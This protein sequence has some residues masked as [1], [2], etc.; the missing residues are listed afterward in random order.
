MH[1]P[2]K[3]ISGKVF[4]FFLMVT[5]LIFM[6]LGTYVTQLFKKQLKEEFCFRVKSELQLIKG[7]SL[8]AIKDYDYFHL[9]KF[10]SFFLQKDPDAVYLLIYEF[11]PSSP[12][13]KV[14]KKGWNKLPWCGGDFLKRP[15]ILVKRERIKND[16]VPLN[17]EIAYSTE[18]LYTKLRNIKETFLEFELILFTIMILLVFLNIHLL[19]NRIK[20]IVSSVKSWKKEGIKTLT[21]QTENDEFTSLTDSIKEMYDEIEKERKIDRLLLKLTTKI[22]KASANSSGVIDFFNEVSSILKNELKLDYVKF[23]RDYTPPPIK[24]GQKVIKLKENP[25]TYIVLEGD[26][27]CWNEIKDIVKNIIDSA[28]LSVTERKKGEHLFMSTIL[29]LANAIDAMSPWTKGHSERVAKIAV[30][31]GETLGLPEETIRNLQIGG[32]LHDIGKLGIPCSILNKPEPLTPEEYEKIK[33]HPIIGYKI[34]SPIQEL[35]D[36]LPIVL[37]HHE[38]CNGSGYPEGLKCDEIPLP[39]KIVAVADVIEAMTTERP[40][41]KAYSF[42]DVL[43]YLKENAG[44]DKLFDPEIVK[45]VD[46]IS[47]KLKKIL[48][49]K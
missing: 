4:F 11:S 40:Y 2:V 31:I 7:S 35:R 44:K 34:L 22:L 25:H 13:I 24:K 47:E 10:L 46:T 33:Q 1:S 37:Y 19:K 3:S 20:F 17:L 5:V 8:I 28:L 23:V 16:P 49:R 6:V 29:A 48:K 39:A 36:V 14:E 12:L 26:V 38:R 41:K 18:R 32:I 45:A 27:P 30:E 9:Y 21:T 43:S 42:E 15:C